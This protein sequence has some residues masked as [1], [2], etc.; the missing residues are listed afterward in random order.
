MATQ[1]A[2]IA[3]QS[4]SAISPARPARSV[5]QRWLLAA[6]LL[7]GAAQLITISALVS[8]DPLAASWSALLL[9][10]APVLLTAVAAFGSRSMARPAAAG[11]A[12]V[13]LVGIVGSLASWSSQVSHPSPLFIPALVAAVVAGVRLLRAS[14]A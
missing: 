1:S 5:T 13:L 9:A 3:V 7:A 4:A 6:F 12:V 8:A 10:I 2:S 14:P 11:A